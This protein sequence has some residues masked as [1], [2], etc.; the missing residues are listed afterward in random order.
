MKKGKKKE[1]RNPDPLASWAIF[2]ARMA[3]HHEQGIVFTDLH[4]GNLGRRSGDIVMIDY[5]A[6]DKFRFPDE[7]DLLPTALLSLLGWLQDGFT[8]A[9]RFGYLH[10]GGPIAR[11]VFDSL[12]VDYGLNSFQGFLELAYT[13][14]PPGSEPYRLDQLKQ[15]NQNWKAR[16]SSLPSGNIEKGSLDV[17]DLDR[18]REKRHRENLRNDFEADEYHY[19]KHLVA[20][21]EQSSLYDFL[22]ALLNLQGLYFTK[23]ELWKAAGFALFC[24]RF[25][26]TFSDPLSER[27]KEQVTYINQQSLYPVQVEEGLKQ[28]PEIGNIFHWL[29]C[30]DDYSLG[31]LSSGRAA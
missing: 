5:G 3:A 6:I 2:G 17:E 27:V 7:W 13:P 12:R 24:N 29:W 23:G 22:E 18:W 11:L 21:L 31:L 10:H 4:Q 30:L 26:T 9:F 19:N 16:R 25:V 20:S 14:I 8:A 15:L 1:E 28:L